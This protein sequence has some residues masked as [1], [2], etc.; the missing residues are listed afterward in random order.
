MYPG[1]V[2]FVNIKLMVS[3]FA[4]DNCWIHFEKLSLDNE[5]KSGKMKR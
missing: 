3:F 5:L 4:M 1:L 2:G